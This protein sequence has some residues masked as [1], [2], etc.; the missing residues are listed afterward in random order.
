[1][2]LEESVRRHRLAILQRAALLGSVTQACREAGISRTLFYRWRRRFLRYGPD[3][4][5]PRPTRPTRWP[6]Q[7]VPALEPGVIHYLEWDVGI[8][9]QAALMI[10]ISL[11]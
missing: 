1:M 5:L 9:Q 4:L 8:F 10:T 7:T 2:T 3:G 6:R 11:K